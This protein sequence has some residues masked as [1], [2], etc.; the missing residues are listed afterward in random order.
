MN[1]PPVS[2]STLERWIALLVRY[3]A[4]NM[5]LASQFGSYWPGFGYSEDEKA[6]MASISQKCSLGQFLVWLL[7]VAF[8]A[9]PVIAVTCMPG[10]Y[11][12]IFK[13]DPATLPESIFFLSL[14]VAIVGCFTIGIPVSMLLSSALVGRLYKVANSDL[15]DRA[16]TARFFHRLWKKLLRPAARA[17][18][19]AALHKPGTVSRELLPV[20]R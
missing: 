6:E 17:L 20:F 15:P 10:M 16:T 4:F 2:R 9:M 14:G 8:V 19:P 5:T 11:F 13:S 12:V 1:V 3:W 7:I 18:I